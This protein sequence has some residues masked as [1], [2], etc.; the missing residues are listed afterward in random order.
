MPPFMIIDRRTML[1]GTAGALA[2]GIVPG[3]LRRAV[4]ADGEFK[5]GLLIPLSG[6]AA[7]FGPSNQGCAELAAD[8]V[9]AA[10]GVL[11][12]KIKLIPTDAGAAPAEVAKSVVRLMLEEKVDLVIGSHDSAV[13]QAVEATVK[14]KGAKSF[15]L[16]GNDYVWARNSNEA[17]KSYIS[18]GGG[19]IAG[20][21]YVPLGA[22]NRFEEIVTRIKGAKPD[23]VLITVIGADNVN[24]NR[25]FASFGLDKDITR[26][27]FL[28][29]E[30][31]LQG[32]GAESSGN[33]YSCM[34]YFANVGSEANQ[35]FKA[36][37][38]AKF[39]DKVPQLSTLGADA[40]AGV[41]CAKALVDKAGSTE[42]A[43]VAAASQGLSFATAGGTATM[44]G[45]HV[46]KDMYLALCKAT[47]FEVVKTFEKIA[48][49]QSCPV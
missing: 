2:A 36:A 8:E 11:G 42:A 4:A 6:P 12:R 5:I 9:N 23:V 34:A 46:D 39:G 48:S 32:I 7:L 22:P 45:R 3:A 18:A 14:G 35:K 21:E 49:G 15:Y 29:E 10:G 25:A 24:F 37:M 31:T 30:N 19:T 16:I 43:A 27:A 28:L 33:L 20:E 26:L 41:H 44:T 13:R 38:K 40:Y 47:E 17:A 1:A